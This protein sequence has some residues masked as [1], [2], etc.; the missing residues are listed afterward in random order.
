M[1]ASPQQR[2]KAP[3]FDI[4]VLLCLERYKAALAAK[5]AAV[6]ELTQ[7]N[8]TAHRRAVIV[9]NANDAA[10]K[11]NNERSSLDALL[12]LQVEAEDP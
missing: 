9:R 2:Q 7:P 8:L 5:R 10:K 12:R 6:R 11:I 1:A 4:V 3:Q